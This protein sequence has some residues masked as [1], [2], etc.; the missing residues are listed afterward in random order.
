MESTIIIPT[1]PLN[2]LY[3]ENTNTTSHDCSISITITSNKEPP[4][5]TT[6]TS[7]FIHNLLPD[8][9]SRQIRKSSTNHSIYSI[10]SGETTQNDINILTSK[11]FSTFCQ[12]Y[13]QR[14]I[15]LQ[16]LIESESPADELFI[17]TINSG[18]MY[19]TDC[20]RSV[21]SYNNKFGNHSLIKILY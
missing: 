8:I 13:Y 10:F 11:C 20:C 18:P 5:D 16:N 9:T 21:Q 3:S 2:S 7:H 17:T 14:Y 1:T 4:N 15:Q 6:E 19:S 12:N